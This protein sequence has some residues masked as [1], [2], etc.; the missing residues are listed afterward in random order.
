[1]RRTNNQSSNEVNHLET[2]HLRSTKISKIHPET[3]YVDSSLNSKVCIWRQRLNLFEELPNV[4]LTHANSTSRWAKFARKSL[5]HDPNCNGN[6][7]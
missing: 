2:N 1:M 3:T 7:A 6:H 5:P 4:N